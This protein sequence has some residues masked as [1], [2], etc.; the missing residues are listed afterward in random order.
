MSTAFSETIVSSQPIENKTLYCQDLP[1]RLVDSMGKVL[2]TGASGYIGGRLVPELVARGYQ[3]RVMVRA[4]SPTY[5]DRWPGVEIVT[6][7]ALNLH[8]LRI[9]LRDEGD[10]Q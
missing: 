6:A 2:V 5:K 9:A 8:D 3:V 4:P 1:S 7:D 10:P